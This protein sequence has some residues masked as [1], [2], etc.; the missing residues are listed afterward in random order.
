MDEEGRVARS[1]KWALGVGLL[2][3]AAAYGGAVETPAAQPVQ[4]HQDIF[5][6]EPNETGRPALT[7]LT[8]ASDTGRVSSGASISADGNRIVFH[9]DSDLLKQ[10]IPQGTP[11]I[12]LYEVPTRQLTRI[13]TASASDRLSL[14]P[15]I[16]ADGSTVAFQS[17]SDFLK[18]GLARGQMEIWRYVIATRALTRVTRGGA[19]TMS[20][21]PAL[22][23]DGRLIAFSSSAALGDG[24]AVPGRQI[25]CFDAGENRFSAITATPSARSERPAL[26]ADGSRI[27]FHSDKNLTADSLA[28]GARD[29]WLFERT[30]GRLTRITASGEQARSSEAPSI[31]ADGTKVVFFSDA[32]LLKEDRPDSVDEIYLYDVTARSLKRI[33]SVWQPAR[34][35]GKNTVLHPDTQYPRITADAR[36][37][38][39]ASDGDFLDEKLPN[40]YP[41][42]WIFDIASGRYTRLD[43]STGSGSGVAVNRDG[44]R[45]VAFRTDFDMVR[46]SRVAPGSPSARAVWMPLPAP[47]PPAPR[48]THLTAEQAATDLDDFQQAIEGR[49]SYLKAN[50]VDY[51]AALGRI[52]E[53]TKQGIGID[54]YGL[55]IQKFI[56]LF[57][58]GHSRVGGYR[59]PPGYLPFLVEPSGARFVAFKPDRS[60][61]IDAELPYVTRIDGRALGDWI[62][63]ARPYAPQGSPQYR[64]YQALRQLRNL[65]FLR[66]VMNLPAPATVRVELQSE[67]RARTREIEMAVSAEGPVSGIWPAST[68]RLLDGNV[69]YLRI[70]SMNSAA[71]DDIRTWMPKF[72]DTRGLIVDVRNNGG[73]SRDALRALF[74]HIMAPGAT[75][76]VVSTAKY[77][78][79]PDFAEDHMGGSRFMFRETWSGWTAADREAIARF[80]GSFKPEWTPPASEFSE[81]HYLV[82]SRELNPE[83]YHYTRPVVILMDQKC[84]SATDIFLSAFKGQPGVTLVGAPSGGGS[85]L[86]V[87]YRMPVSRLS[88]TLASMASFQRTGQL[89]DTRGVQPDVIV[90]PAPTYFLTGGRDDVLERALQIIK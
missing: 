44:S 57:I 84:F 38:V 36:K 31:S 14:N 60:G 85:A 90:E 40:G 23:A 49:W 89:Y 62:E 81:W 51:R 88:M 39:F 80:K 70:V 16:S 54:E 43:T 72:R 5:L 58:D 22:S 82:M 46:G 65:Q 47:P 12:W 86:Q 61:L 69:G 21:E 34:D 77:R 45:I 41:H 63:A 19:R 8:T 15:V 29:I 9:S 11:E 76:V 74:P 53:K 64:T 26:S 7:R 59:T 20:V 73:G 55:E 79:H 52:R 6:Y 1:L 67:D 68:S 35:A 2:C 32:D 75:P 30:N 33:T 56:S 48:L 3:A 28:S 10:G 78:L 27:V 13:T 37:I 18:E 17:D 66:Q 4:V 83:A 24:P 25:W 71:V 42:I 50:G 87:G